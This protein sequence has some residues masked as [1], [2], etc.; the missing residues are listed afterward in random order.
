M[1]SARGFRL[2]YHPLMIAAFAARVDWS[3]F[4]AYLE[5]SV[6]VAGATGGRIRA[7]LGKG[8]AHPE[9]PEEFY[10]GNSDQVEHHDRQDRKDT[11]E[12]NTDELDDGDKQEA[13]HQAAQQPCETC[14]QLSFVPTIE[15]Q[16]LH[17]ALSWKPGTHWTEYSQMR[18]NSNAQ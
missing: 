14:E 12:I 5:G 15:T 16:V 9:T 11:G 4:P 13:A 8:K 17:S 7:Q 10:D 6:A 3:R 2:P 1:I 18:S